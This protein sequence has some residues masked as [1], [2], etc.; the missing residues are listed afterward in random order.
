MNE[1][2]YNKIMKK[3]KK[4]SDQR[5]S[6][7]CFCYSYIMSINEY[8]YFLSVFLFQYVCKFS[9]VNCAPLS[10]L[11]QIAKNFLFSSSFFVFYS[12]NLT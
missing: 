11:M 8:L 4:I 1:K 12:K 5:I 7:V 2:K 6:V 3:C 9:Q 10:K